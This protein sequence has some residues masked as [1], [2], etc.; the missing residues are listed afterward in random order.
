MLTQMPHSLFGT[1]WKGTDKIL[2][3]SLSVLDKKLVFAL[4]TFYGV[5]A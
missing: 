3:S 5:A 1:F 4:F 2:L